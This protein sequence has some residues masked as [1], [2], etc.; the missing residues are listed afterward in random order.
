[1]I[2]SDVL[3]EAPSLEEAVRRHLEAGQPSSPMSMVVN[4]RGLVPR[5]LFSLSIIMRSPRWL[6][7]KVAAAAGMVASE[8]F[9]LW[10]NP[11]EARYAFDGRNPRA[12]IRWA[13]RIGAM[14]RPSRLG[15]ITLL[16]LS[17]LYTEFVYRTCAVAVF[18]VPPKPT[19][20]S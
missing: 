1:M 14:G 16:R 3:S 9:L 2:G 8:H 12:S 5:N 10:P 19:Q 18:L 11:E 15:P 7:E 17:P 13:R 20:R 4:R 6:A